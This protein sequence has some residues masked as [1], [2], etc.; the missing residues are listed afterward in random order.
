LTG[1]DDSFVEFNKWVLGEDGTVTYKPISI[2]FEWIVSFSS[3]NAGDQEVLR[4]I[5]VPMSVIK[6]RDG[7][8]VLVMETYEEV[9][10]KMEGR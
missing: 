8:D 5:I 4:Y 1:V 7:N 10:Q 2:S 3:L 9:K 6:L